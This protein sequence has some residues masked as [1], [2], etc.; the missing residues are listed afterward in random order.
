MTQVATSQ[1]KMNSRILWIQFLAG[2]VLWSAHFLL[3]YF[4]V[5]LFCQAGWHFRLLGM[6]GLSLIVIVLTILAILGTGLFGLKSYRGWRNIHTERSLRDEFRE[7]SH[8]FEGTADFMYFSGL[9]LSVLFAATIL[10]VGLPVFF[11]QPC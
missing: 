9:L 7:S 3:S 4:L 10:M 6:N 11:L 8:W 5:E 1:Q 2:P